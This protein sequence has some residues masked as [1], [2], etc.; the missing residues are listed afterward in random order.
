MYKTPETEITHDVIID[1]GHPDRLGLRGPRRR[2]VVF[3]CVSV[4]PEWNDEFERYMIGL[5]MISDSTFELIREDVQTYM[6]GVGEK[7]VERIECKRSYV[8]IAP[9]YIL[10]EPA[11]FKMP[12]EYVESWD[13]DADE[14][15][16]PSR[17]YRTGRWFA[18]CFPGTLN[19][20]GVG[21]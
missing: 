18:K 15:I 19:L 16:P 2:D 7:A 5:F 3:R 9:L 12:M 11:F 6:C 4:N 21:R 20:L 10:P 14:F 13:I 1:P 8:E 17:M